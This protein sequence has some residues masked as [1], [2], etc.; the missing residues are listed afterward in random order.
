MSDES[1][2]KTVEI[3][4]S[5]IPP[6]TSS[7]NN[8]GFSYCPSS[9]FITI[10]CFCVGFVLIPSVHS[11]LRSQRQNKNDVETRNTQD[12]EPSARENGTS[13]K[14]TIDTKV[15]SYPFNSHTEHMGIPLVYPS[16]IKP[17][18]MSSMC[19]AFRS[20]GP[21]PLPRIRW[22]HPDLMLNQN[23]YSPTVAASKPFVSICASGMIPNDTMMDWSLPYLYEHV[24]EP[25]NGHFYISTWDMVMGE[26]EKNGDRVFQGY[27]DEKEVDRRLRRMMEWGS[28]STSINKIRLHGVWMS[29][30]SV[31]GLYCEPHI[32]D[33]RGVCVVSLIRRMCMYAIAQ[34]PYPACPTHV[35]LLRMNCVV[36]HKLKL[37]IPTPNP[38]FWVLQVGETMS[39]YDQL[40][41]HPYVNVRNDTVICDTKH[42]RVNKKAITWMNDMYNM[43]T[44]ETMVR[45][46]RFWLHYYLP[47]HAEI[48]KEGLIPGTTK[49]PCSEILHS[50]FARMH[51]MIIRPI[52]FLLTRWGSFIA[53][54][55]IIAMHPNE[56]GN[57]K[58]WCD[59]WTTVLMSEPAPPY[60]VVNGDVVFI[61][62]KRGMRCT[63]S[64][65]Q[66]CVKFSGCGVRRRAQCTVDQL[67]TNRT[68]WLL[69]FNQ[70]NEK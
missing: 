56:E 34:E 13:L 6:P 68:A 16:P 42:V 4:T 39:I 5:T 69:N 47:G 62:L 28:G 10:V 48:L 27:R 51:G 63:S 18:P 21:T 30:S 61:P 70:T 15:D 38:G 46:L 44:T 49:E 36:G 58:R 57:S 37:W 65:C 54:Y 64:W 17:Y 22:S 66:C 33:R 60:S 41:Y 7:P 20:L 1:P 52:N 50:R 26:R 31:G 11:T 19:P 14:E 29:N 12:D 40:L 59:L 43:A 3:T 45:L 2:Q 25:L 35:M 8:N 53:D 67:D 55:R 23:R 9:Y 24:I 32:G